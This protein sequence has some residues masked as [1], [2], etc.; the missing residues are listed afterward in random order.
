VY[1]V[2]TIG[3]VSGTL[4]AGFLLIPRLGL[5]TTLAVAAFCLVAAALAVVAAADVNDRTRL[6]GYAMSAVAVA[7]IVLAP[8]WDRALIASGVYLLRA[9]RAESL[10]LDTQLKAGTLLYYKDG[11]PA[12]VSVKRLTGTTT[13]AVDGKTDASN[14]SDMLTQK[15]VAHLPMLL[16]PKPAH[17]LPSSASAAASRSEQR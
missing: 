1:A 6:V 4:A 3:S 5:P 12:T 16:H 7:A 2:N 15:L 14:R 17:G 9:V 13:L 10:D 11:A 8:Q